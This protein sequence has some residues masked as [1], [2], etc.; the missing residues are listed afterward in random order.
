MTFTL[1]QTFGMKSVVLL[2]NKEE[3]IMDIWLTWIFMKIDFIVIRIQK[4][5]RHFL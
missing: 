3:I 4:N 1:K 5:F 2:L